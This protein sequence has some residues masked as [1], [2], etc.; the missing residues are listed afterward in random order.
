MEVRNAQ[1]VQVSFGQFDVDQ[2]PELL[3]P[4]VGQ[5]LEKDS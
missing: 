3:D 1:D 2:L 5:A 4:L